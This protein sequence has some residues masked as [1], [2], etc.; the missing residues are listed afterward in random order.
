MQQ[1]KQ[2]RR[3]QTEH[4]NLPHGM[5]QGLCE[6]G[7]EGMV[8]VHVDTQA[9]GFVLLGFCFRNH[10]RN[11]IKVCRTRRIAI[12]CA[13]YQLQSRSSHAAWWCGLC[14]P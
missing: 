11:G 3:E 12:E 13:L 1:A 7:F 2:Q 4:G 10:L 14:R 9:S 5:Q 8:E 6:H